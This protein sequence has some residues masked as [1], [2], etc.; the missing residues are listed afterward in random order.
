MLAACRVARGCEPCPPSISRSGLSRPDGHYT[1]AILAAFADG[2]IPLFV[3]RVFAFD[4]P[5]QAKA[6]IEN[7][8]HKG[9]IVLRITPPGLMG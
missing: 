9:K 7:H 6:L 3:N 2:R 4:E 8:P 1:S 5:G